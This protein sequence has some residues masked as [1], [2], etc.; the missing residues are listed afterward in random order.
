MTMLHHTVPSSGQFKSL[1]IYLFL[2]GHFLVLFFGDYEIAQS[3]VTSALYVKTIQTF[4]SVQVF[5][6]KNTIDT[7]GTGT[8]NAL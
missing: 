8:S 3:T 1:S 6:A 4:F 5:L 7:S 2:Q